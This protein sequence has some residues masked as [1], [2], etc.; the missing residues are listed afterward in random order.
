MSRSPCAPESAFTYYHINSCELHI[1]DH[2]H[3]AVSSVHAVDISATLSDDEVCVCLFLMRQCMMTFQLW[4]WCSQKVQHFRQTLSLSS[5]W[6]TWCVL[7]V[8]VQ[9]SL[10]QWLSIAVTNSYITAFSDN[11]SYSAYTS[12]KGCCRDTDKKG[13]KRKGQ[14]D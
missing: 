7:Q 9:H 10:H 8:C 6:R 12:R 11:I 2:K 3:T 1:S 5:I 14:R 4:R 13:A